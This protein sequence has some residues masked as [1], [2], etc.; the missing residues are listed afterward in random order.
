MIRAGPVALRLKG[1][2]GLR[3]SAIL[4]NVKGNLNISK[5]GIGFLPRERERAVDKLVEGERDPGK[6]GTSLRTAQRWRARGIQSK[7]ALFH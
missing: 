2:R 1:S 6:L 4:M 7:C 3:R 5:G